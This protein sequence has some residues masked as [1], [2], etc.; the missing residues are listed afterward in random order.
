MALL[1][2]EIA[3]TNPSPSNFPATY[4]CSI[5]GEY[6]HETLASKLSDDHDLT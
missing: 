2:L 4:E 3:P 6:H 5:E 1:C